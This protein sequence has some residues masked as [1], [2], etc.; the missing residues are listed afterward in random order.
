M[1]NPQKPSIQLMTKAITP[2]QFS[3]VFD[4]IFNGATP[5]TQFPRGILVALS[6]GVDSMAL[7]YLLSKTYCA[8]GGS[9]RVMTVD[10]GL[11][12]ES[13]HETYLV[14]Q[15]VE[16]MGKK[17]PR[18]NFQSTWLLILMYRSTVFQKKNQMA[19]QHPSSTITLGNCCSQGSL[20]S[21]DPALPLPRH[22]SFVFWSH[23]GRSTRNNDSTL[24]FP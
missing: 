12:P 11:R 4:S 1:P 5:Q 23:A 18:I 13:R 15:A 10:H 3:K 8:R 20:R 2:A 24:H 17:K 22:I 9:L 6:G 16:T 19:K 7:L 21:P 14:G